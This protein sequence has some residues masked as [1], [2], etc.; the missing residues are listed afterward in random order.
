MFEHD[1]DDQ[2]SFRMFTSQLICQNSCRQSEIVRTFGV[3]ANSVKRSVKKYREQG[4]RSFYQPRPG[5]GATVMTPEVVE[6][7]QALLFQGRSRTQDSPRS[8][9]RVLPRCSQYVTV[10]SGRR[11]RKVKHLLGDAWYSQMRFAWRDTR[12]DAALING[13]GGASFQVA[14]RRAAGGDG[15]AG[16]MSGRKT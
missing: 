10:P 9:R 8:P 12:C 16:R 7:A 14:R 6:Q 5:R 11:T 3:S 4:I 2:R 1:E 13:P 15:I